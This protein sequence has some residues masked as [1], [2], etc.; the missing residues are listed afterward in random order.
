MYDALASTLSGIVVTLLWD[1]Q[2]LAYI[3]PGTG[4]TIFAS[5][6]PLLAGILALFAVIARYFRTI[7][8]FIKGLFSRPP[9]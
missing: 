8:S 4:G 9:K 6:A 5:L 2:A 3:D 7:L 1:N